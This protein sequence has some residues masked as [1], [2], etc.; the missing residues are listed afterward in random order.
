M[1]EKEETVSSQALLLCGEVMVN[2]GKEG[3]RGVGI[4]EVESIGSSIV[5]LSDTTIG[6]TE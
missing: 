3:K 5:S 1:E 6:S 4:W 2:A